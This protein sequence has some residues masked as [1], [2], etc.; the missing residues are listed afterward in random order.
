MGA[1]EDEPV[2]GAEAIV[3]LRRRFSV[4]AEPIN[5]EVGEM[6]VG[7]EI[8]MARFCRLDVI[9]EPIS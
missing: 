3:A 2:M 6:T 7:V 8:S 1:T 5:A 4:A 9:T